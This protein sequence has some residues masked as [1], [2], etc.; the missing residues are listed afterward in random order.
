ML[1]APSKNA[2]HDAP[3]IAPSFF[4][5]LIAGIVCYSFPGPGSRLRHVERDPLT[6][7]YA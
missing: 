3:R 6:Y 1:R 4:G 7:E 5:A 2:P